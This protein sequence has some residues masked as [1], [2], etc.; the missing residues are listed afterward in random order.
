MVPNIE[1]KSALLQSRLI[2]REVQRGVMSTDARCSW[3]SHTL[4]VNFFSGST[5]FLPA[6]PCD[7]D[8]VR[9]FPWRFVK[10]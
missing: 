4:A 9:K 2:D 1:V 6:P 3:V 10:K 7:V 5:L 8:K